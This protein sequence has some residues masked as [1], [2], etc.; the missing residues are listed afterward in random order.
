MQDSLYKELR[1]WAKAIIIAFFVVFFMKFFLF[2]V[3]AI[4]GI[5]MVPTLADRDRVFV[6]IMGYK[7]SGPERQ[8][9][10][11]FA[12]S[13]DPKSLYIKRVIGV[14]GDTVSIKDGK[15]YVND[16]EL[17]EYYL[18]PGEYTEGDVTL[19]VPDDSVFVL[20]DNRSNSE[21]SRDKRLGPIPVKSIKGK[22]LYRVFPV[23]NLKKL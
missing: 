4:S 15:V 16:M 22:A 9:I 17:D 19:K 10:V 1:E 11:I 21:D 23:K 14:A 8:D 20:G 12:P 3:I 2:D 7:L 13:I 6:N 18:P 5:S